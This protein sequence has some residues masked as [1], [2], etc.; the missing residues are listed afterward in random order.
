MIIPRSKG[1][2]TILPLMIR[3]KL[4]THSIRTIANQQNSQYDFQH[5]NSL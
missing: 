4:K 2:I 3:G 1:P 5:T